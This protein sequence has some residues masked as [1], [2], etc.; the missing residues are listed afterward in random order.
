MRD[1]NGNHAPGK[2]NSGPK[3]A[4]PAVTADAQRRVYDIL[5]LLMP[6]DMQGVGKRRIGGDGDG[7][8]V[9]ADLL[10]PDQPILS[11]GVGPDVSFDLEL[12]QQGHMI[13]MFDHTVDELPATH[14]HFVWHKLGIAAQTAEDGVLRSLDDLIALLPQTG[15][16][17]VLKIDVEGAEWESLAA[18]SPRSL[19]RFAQIAIELHTLLDL[20][21]PGFGA[22]AHR[23]L[24]NLATD[25]VPVHVHGNNFGIAGLVGGFACPETLE[26]T[27]VRR[28]L[29]TTLPSATW[30]PTGFDRPN[31]NEQPDHLLWHFPFAPGS[32]AALLA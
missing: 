9:L 13:V 10:T 12:A 30:Y 18:A 24:S 16:D 26:L 25:F 27:Y 28:D 14:A 17:P 19:R 7:G 32:A 20:S 2:P 4:L 21:E 3:A 29:I 1:L 31:F 15:A 6:Y 11:L 8:Y 23:M 22:R 5:R